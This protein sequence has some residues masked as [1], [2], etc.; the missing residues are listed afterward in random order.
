MRVVNNWLFLQSWSMSLV[1]LQAWNMT[2]MR[3]E[4]VGWRWYANWEYKNNVKSN[5]VHINDLEERLK[6]HPCELIKQALKNLIL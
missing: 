3:C 5:S 4:L 2:L 1:F 6:P